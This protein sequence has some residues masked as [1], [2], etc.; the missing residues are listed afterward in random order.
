MAPETPRRILMVFA[1]APTPGQVKTR[2]AKELG[3]T[4]AADIYRRLGRR[5]VRQLRGGDY[6]MVIYYDPPASEPEIRTWLGDGEHEYL[7]QRSGD[8]GE[9]L[10]HAVEWGF[11]EGDLVCVVGTDIPGLDRQKVESAFSLLS[12][13][14]G[15][16]AVFGPAMDGGYYL[17]ALRRPAPDLFRG[18]PWSTDRVLEESMKRANGLGL[19][20]ESLLALTDVDRVEDLPDEFRHYRWRE[21]DSGRPRRT[22]GRSLER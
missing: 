14:E 8:L 15:A 16:D 17:L 7:P 9:R 22:G 12:D 13:P 1:K 21:E 2:I 6:R 10:T 20:V 18:I 5:M 19:K 4:A 3:A 11:G